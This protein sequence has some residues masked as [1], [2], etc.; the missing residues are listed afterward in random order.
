MC[1]CFTAK[2]MPVSPTPIGWRRRWKGRGDPQ[3]VCVTCNDVMYPLWQTPPSTVKEIGTGTSLFVP[4]ICTSF[5][6][7]GGFPKTEALEI[8]KPGRSRRSS[9]LPCMAFVFSVLALL[10]A[11]VRIDVEEGDYIP[12]TTTITSPPPSSSTSTSVWWS[13]KARSAMKLCFNTVSATVYRHSCIYNVSTRAC[14]H[15]CSCIAFCIHAWSHTFCSS[16]AP[17]YL[18]ERAAI[19][20][21]NEMAHCC[22]LNTQKTMVSLEE[23]KPN[24]FIH[25]RLS[26]SQPSKCWIFLP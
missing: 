19:S 20:F 26:T 24:M 12:G 17:E 6:C 3:P 10:C 15:V 25:C 4:A 11:F 1:R 22:T 14:V 23:K 2:R 5:F 21:P 16:L 8:R 9:F 18:A 13:N 7:C